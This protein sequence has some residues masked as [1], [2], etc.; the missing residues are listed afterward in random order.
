MTEFDTARP[1]APAPPAGS[2]I[3]SL[4][5]LRFF[6]AAFVLVCHTQTSET[7]PSALTAH[8]FLFPKM[9]VTF[10]FILSGFVLAWSYRPDYPARSFY[11]R[12]FARVWPVHA[13]VTVLL[14]GIGRM[15]APES[16]GFGTYL[17]VWLSVLLLVQSLCPLPSV[18]EAVNPPAWTLSVEAFFYALFP[19][20]RR[21]T[22]TLSPQRLRVLVA[23]MFVACL[24][25]WV[26]VDDAAWI[27][28]YS[29]GEEQTLR[30][31]PALAHLPE[32]VLGLA[33]AGLLRHKPSFP[34]SPAVAVSLAGA[35]LAVLAVLHVADA[36]LPLSIDA[37]AQLGSIPISFLILGAFAARELNGHRTRLHNPW[38]IRFGDWSYALYLI[39]LTIIH[40]AHLALGQPGPSPLNVLAAPVFLAVSLAVAAGLHYGVERP[41]KRRILRRQ[42]RVRQEVS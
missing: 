19:L 10:F 27:Y 3:D 1:Q 24:A 18:H 31:L 15:I 30:Y 6:A 42:N 28:F 14:F 23:A 11:L 17:V 40:V 5:S 34:V 8:L 29:G 37:V 36:A 22:A 33:L 41:A 35:W 39:H 16:W 13:V 21:R 25:I 7:F 9:G 38:L 20:L 26:F 12:R 4:T 2:R 32:F